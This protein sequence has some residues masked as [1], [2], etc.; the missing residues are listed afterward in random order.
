MGIGRRA[1]HQASRPGR[2]VFGQNSERP[3]LRAGLRWT[4][5]AKYLDI[6]LTYVT[7]PGGTRNERFVSLG[8][9]LYGPPILP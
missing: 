6:D 2:E 1:H 9:V 3:F 5:I 8:F 7:R 4:P